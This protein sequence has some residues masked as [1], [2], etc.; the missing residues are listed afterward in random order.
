MECVKNP[1]F[2]VEFGEE[3]L[4]NIRTQIKKVLKY[5]ELSMT[6]LDNPHISISYVLGNVNVKTIEEAAEQI[7][8]APFK[9]TIRGIEAV[10]SEYYGGTIISLLLSHTDDFLYSQEF[11]KESF[12]NEQVKIKEYSGGFQAHVSLFVLKD[13]TPKEKKLIPRYIE[14]C[15]L[16]LGGLEIQGEKFCMYDE[17][18]QK[19]LEKNFKT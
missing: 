18:R 12:A 13:L 3:Q 11:L 7:V 8:E 14:V 17:N 5:I 4:G 16:N 1:Y 2:S 9:M 6:D 10:E 15:L 19:L